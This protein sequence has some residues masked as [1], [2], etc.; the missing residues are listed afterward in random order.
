MKTI[1][2]CLS[3]KDLYFIEY[4][5][6]FFIFFFRFSLDLHLINYLILIKKT[7]IDRN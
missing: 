5:L 6:F 7:H 2:V 3:W 4:Q 1:A